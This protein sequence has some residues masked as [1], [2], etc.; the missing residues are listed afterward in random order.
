MVDSE[1]KKTVRN[2]LIQHRQDSVSAEKKIKDLQSQNEGLKTLNDNFSA[3]SKADADALQSSKLEIETLKAELKSKQD[4]KR[5]LIH[6][7]RAL[8]DENRDLVDQKSAL[9]GE[10]KGI[11]LEPKIDECSICFETVSLERKWTA[12]IHCGHRTCA[13]CAQQISSLP[14]TTYL[15]KCPNCRENINN[16][17]VLEGIYES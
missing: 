10:L 12:F 8:A 15:R 7:K 9:E 1:W 3:A 6:Q 2:M 11:K 16:F 14:R 4:L 5:S 13:V 17:L